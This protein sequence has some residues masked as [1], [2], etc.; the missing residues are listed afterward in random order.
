VRLLQLSTLWQ[1]SSDASTIPSCFYFLNDMPS[2]LHHS[3]R[4]IASL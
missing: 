3:C 1:R 2:H 4:L